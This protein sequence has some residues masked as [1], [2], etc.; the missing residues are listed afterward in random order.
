MGF[1]GAPQYSSLGLQIPIVKY[2]KMVRSSIGGFLDY[3]KAGAINKLSF[4]LTYGYHF[5]PQ[6][7][8]YNEDYLS[9]GF[10]VQAGRYRFDPSN[11]N[12]Y[13]G[14]IGDPNLK[15]ASSASIKPNATIGI[16]CKSS[17]SYEMQSHLLRPHGNQFFPGRIFNERDLVLLLMLPHFGYRRLIQVNTVSLNPTS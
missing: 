2:G 17:G 6:L 11:L 3:D 9:I 4:N 8:G 12:A 1:A 5:S 16:F 15:D 10:G 13:D 14:I 7:F